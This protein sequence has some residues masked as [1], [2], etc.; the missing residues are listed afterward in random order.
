LTEASKKL[1][2]RKCERSEH[3]QYIKLYF[4]SDRLSPPYNA[5]LFDPSATALI[6]R[7]ALIPAAGMNSNIYI[8]ITVIH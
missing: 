1:K 3:F 5:I 8:P 4:I 2:I 6:R 7:L